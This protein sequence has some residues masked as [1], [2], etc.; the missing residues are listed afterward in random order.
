MN[1]LSFEDIL[2]VHIL[3]QINNVARSILN[4]E[5]ANSLII[6]TSDWFSFTRNEPRPNSSTTRF[7]ESDEA[8]EE[9]QD[10]AV[11]EATKKDNHESDKK[12]KEKE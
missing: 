12:I 6:D 11:D 4:D 9:E 10:R 7:D 5:E 8:E 2:R 1:P 3:H